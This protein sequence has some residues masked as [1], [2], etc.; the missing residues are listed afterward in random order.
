MINDTGILDHT[1][2][3]LLPTVTFLL[4]HF[5]QPTDYD[6]TEFKSFE[7]KEKVPLLKRMRFSCNLTK[8]NPLEEKQNFHLSEYNRHNNR[9]LITLSILMKMKRRSLR[10]N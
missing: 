4:P 6:E 2:A 8:S 3:K 5:F 9:V 7:I 10:K 1:I